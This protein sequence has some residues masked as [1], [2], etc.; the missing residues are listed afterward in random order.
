MASPNLNQIVT[1]TLE[2][3]T[4]KLADNISASNALLL[5]VKEKGNSKKVSGGRSLVKELEYAENGTFMMYSGG[6]QL[7]VQASDTFTAA[8]YDWKQAAVSVVMDGLEMIKNSGKEA[9]I[10]LL[11]AKIKN[12]EKTMKNNIS[13]GVYSDGTAYSGKQIGGLQLL[14][15]DSPSTGT[16]GGINRATYSFWRNVSFDASSDGGAAATSANIQSYM[17]RVY[18]QLVRGTD[19]PD[20]IVADNNYY[21]LYMESLQTIQ[22][23]TS[24]KM[25][26]AGFESLKYMGSDVVLDGG[27]GGDAPTDHM[28]FLNTDYL[29]FETHKD[30]NFVELNPDRFATNQDAMV[31]IIAWAGNMTMSNASLQ[32]VLK[33]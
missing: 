1:T 11:E 31:K 14:V 5:R 23:V 25:A 26:Q 13:V 7:S 33:A 16:V 19:K 32:G 22:R 28:Y 29:F 17:N 10:D 21:R 2:Y 8:E 9:V 24:D 15:A 12:A 18:I 3:R 4:G 30:R 27:F 20:L 6:E